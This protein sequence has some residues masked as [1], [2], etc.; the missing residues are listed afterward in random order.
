MFLIV[1]ATEQEMAPIRRSLAG[2]SGWTPFVAGI[3]WLESAVNLTRF[4]DHHPD[5]FQA[6]I[7][8]GVGGAFVGAGPTLLDICLA[9][10]EILAD[11]G[12]M[13]DDGVQPFDTILVPTH[14]PMDHSL[15][16]KTKETLA[17]SGLQ[18]WSG[19]FVSVMAVSGTLARG[20]ELRSR[21][22][23]ICENMEG[24]AIARVAEEFRL[25]CLEI[26]AISNMVE[27]RNLS[28][29]RMPEAIERCAEAMAILLPGLSH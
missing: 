3:G 9:E 26:R 16:T 5:T 4:L 14:F 17:L 29:W 10:T 20:K 27:D 22:G 24:A 18:P 13:L 15:L 8:C 1:T 6:I 23:A 11:V 28:A 19:P 21:F 12:V 25:P 2:T 7:N